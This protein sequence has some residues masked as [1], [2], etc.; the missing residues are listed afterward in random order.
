MATTTWCST[1]CSCLCCSALA[2]LL[3]NDLNHLTGKKRITLDMKTE[4]TIEKPA[5][6]GRATQIAEMAIT[7]LVAFIWVYFGRLYLIHDP[8][9]WRIANQQLGYPL[10]IIPLIG[11]T[12]ILGGVGLLIPNLPR[13]TEWVY[14][15]IVIDLLLA[16]YSQL[17]GGDSTWDKFDPILVMAFVFASYVLRRFM[18]AKR[19]SI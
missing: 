3:Q 1:G 16:F 17:N 11:V 4:H 7:G 19:W 15:G 5:R 9:E 13:L 2:D 8:G 6:A 10:Y 12:H 14:A 18:H